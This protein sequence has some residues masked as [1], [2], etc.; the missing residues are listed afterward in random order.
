MTPKPII[1]VI[2]PEVARR[3]LEDAP[4]VRRETVERYAADMRAGRWDASRSSMAFFEDGRV[5][6]GYHR[7]HACV[8]ASCSFATQIILVPASWRSPLPPP[9]TIIV[10]DPREEID[11]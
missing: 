9:S 2:T 6:D 7:L 11:P 10:P 8:E 4:P 5:C 3:Y 1:V